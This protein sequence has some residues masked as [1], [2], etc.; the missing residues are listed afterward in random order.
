MDVEHEAVYGSVIVPACTHH[1]ERSNTY[2][3]TQQIWQISYDIIITPQ[4]WS[5][6]WTA[7]KRN[8]EKLTDDESLCFGCL[9]FPPLNFTFISRSIRNDIKINWTR[10]LSIKL[11]WAES[12]ESLAQT[13]HFDQLNVLRLR[14]VCVR[15]LERGRNS[16]K[17]RRIISFEK[18]AK[19]LRFMFFCWCRSDYCQTRCAQHIS[20]HVI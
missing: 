11:Y 2:A 5:G 16:S 19:T 18:C 13:G 7:S 9:P 20:M 3:C 4:M 12:R 10:T 1:I 17:K 8:N 15:A 14:V 6:R